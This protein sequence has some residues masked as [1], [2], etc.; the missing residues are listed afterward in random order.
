MTKVSKVSVIYLIQSV[1]TNG[2][3]VSVCIITNLLG[4]RVMILPVYLHK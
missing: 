4:F 2:V 1:N 3:I